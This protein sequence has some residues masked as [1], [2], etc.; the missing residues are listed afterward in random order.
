MAL[1]YNIATRT[2]GT[3]GARLAPKKSPLQKPEGVAAP[4]LAKASPLF[5][6]SKLINA[7]Y[8]EAEGRLGTMQQEAARSALENAQRGA[9]INNTTGAGFNTKI[10]Q[11]AV[12]ESSK[13]FLDTRAGLASDRAGALVGAGTA[14]DAMKEQ[15]RQFD[16]SA[17]L[18]KYA[19]TNEMDL[20]RL[21]QFVNSMT[22]M[23]ETINGDRFNT[24]FSS[25]EVSKR[26][27]QAGYA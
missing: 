4:K 27:S 8:D 18:Q 12:N 7:Q 2:S 24:M 17:G 9:A 3:P 26:F 11:D 15:Q 20:S 10:Q 1:P 5:N 25:N 23:K 19:A 14:R 13:P 16:F 6:A 21:G 22:A